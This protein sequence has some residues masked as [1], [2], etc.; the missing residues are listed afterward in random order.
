V[1]VDKVLQAPRDLLEVW[2]LH[3]RRV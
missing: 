2:R 3:R 1:I